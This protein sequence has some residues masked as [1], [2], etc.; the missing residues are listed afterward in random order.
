VGGLSFEATPLSGLLLVRGAAARD[1]RG[2]LERV[3]DADAFSAWRADLR[4]AQANVSRTHRAG[5]IRGMHF[6][7]PPAAEAKL[8]GCLRGRVF[9]V[10]VDLRAGSPTFLRWHGVV[11]EQDVPTQILI[12]EGF[13]HGFQA[14]TDDVQLLYFHTASW[15]PA[16]E[17][18]VRYDDP[19]LAIAWP[20][21]V[22]HVS[23]RDRDAAAL[24]ADY[25]GVALAPDAQERPA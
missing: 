19:A 3:F 15:S 10:A 7:H 9:D 1:E 16:H 4:W 23:E 14:L 5:T 2:S 13:A 20:L 11:L 22:T 17:G 24:P 18:R 25:A 8:I 6:Q 12:P 21:P